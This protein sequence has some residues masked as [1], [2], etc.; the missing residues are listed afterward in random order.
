V[1]PTTE[2]QRFEEYKTELDPE[3]ELARG[4]ARENPVIEENKN[5]N[6]AA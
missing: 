3:T 5:E 2:T 4:T 6:P 1:P